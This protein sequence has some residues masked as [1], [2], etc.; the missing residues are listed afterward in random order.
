MLKLETLTEKEY[1]EKKKKKKRK[2]KMVEE[3]K[4]EEAWPRERKM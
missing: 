4:N 1:T 2:R 3:N